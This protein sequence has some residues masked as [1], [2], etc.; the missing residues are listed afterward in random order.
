MP[1]R[2]EFLKIPVKHI[3]VP[4]NSFALAAVGVMYLRLPPVLPVDVFTYICAIGPSISGASK[5]R[6]NVSVLIF[7]H[8]SLVDVLI[9]NSKGLAARRGVA[10]SL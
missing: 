8:S 2:P 9:K 3:Y 4:I 5:S 10:N 1:S 7:S 6:S